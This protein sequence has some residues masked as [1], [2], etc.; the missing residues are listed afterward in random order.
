M[1]ILGWWPHGIL[2]DRG[3][4][5]HPGEGTQ[6]AGGILPAGFLLPADLYPEGEARIC[7]QPG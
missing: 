5:T 4:I 1:A 2:T 3:L 7:Q 6:R